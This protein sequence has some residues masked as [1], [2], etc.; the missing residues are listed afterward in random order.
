MERVMDR[1]RPALNQVNI[2]SRDPDASVAFYRRLGVDIPDGNVWRTASGA[3][4]ISANEPDMPERIHLDI[5]STAFAQRWNT[6]W[7]GRGD[8]AGRVVVGF[9]IP[10]RDD[11][12]TIYRDMTA[13]G[14]RGLQPPVDAFWGA[15]Y[16]IVEDPDGIAVGLMSPIEAGKKSPP[17]EV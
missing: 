16:A 3:H 17:P 2:V 12:D 7:A 14:H 8:L 6:G 13:A 15:R 1:A 11:V 4:H 5:D 9:G 10:T